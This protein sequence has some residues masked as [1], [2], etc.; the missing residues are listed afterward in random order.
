M[1]PRGGGGRV[2]RGPHDHLEAII[3]MSR[4]TPRK[5]KGAAGWRG[6]R[7]AGRPQA[8]PSPTGAM[9]TAVL[10]APEGVEDL[11][12]PFTRPPSFGMRVSAFRDR[13]R[14]RGPR[15]SREMVPAQ[16]SADSG[17]G[18]TLGRPQASPALVHRAFD[19]TGCV[20]RPSRPRPSYLSPVVG[21]VAGPWLRPWLQVG[22]R[23][24][25]SRRS[26]PRNARGKCDPG[27]NCSLSL[28]V[29]SFRF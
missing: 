18:R 7:P 1:V 9:A 11:T 6:S 25:S 8:A 3:Y 12:L 5:A 23:S 14:L 21:A 29:F 10:M 20:S 27:N 4:A 28:G 19:S 13:R 26:P 2:R 15:P 16:T 17:R 22:P 24:R